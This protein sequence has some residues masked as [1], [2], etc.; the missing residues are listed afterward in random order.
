M[1]LLGRK[2]GES[3]VLPQLGI[4]IVITRIQRDRVS[5]GI[6]APNE[7]TILRKELLLRAEEDERAN[8]GSYGSDGTCAEQRS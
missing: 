1:L 2:A 8:G 3:I 6:S 7:I 5:V 4:E